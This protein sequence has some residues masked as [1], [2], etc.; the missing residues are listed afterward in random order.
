MKF[1]L[2]WTEDEEEEVTGS[3][4]AASRADAVSPALSVQKVP[5]SPK[6]NYRT[7]SILH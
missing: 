3:G 4:G 5:T 1:E 2:G 7:M 6:G